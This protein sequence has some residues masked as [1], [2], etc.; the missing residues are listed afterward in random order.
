MSLRVNVEVLVDDTSEWFAF[1]GG[2]KMAKLGLEPPVLLEIDGDTKQRF[3]TT[4]EF[5]AFAQKA[6]QQWMHSRNH[7]RRN[8]QSLLVE[9]AIRHQDRYFS[10]LEVASEQVV[11]A[12]SGADARN[13]IE[14]A[15]RPFS[16]GTAILVEYAP[17]SVRD[18][19]VNNAV[20]GL[21][22]MARTIRQNSVETEAGERAVNATFNGFREQIEGI[23]E[24]LETVNKRSN[25]LTDKAVEIEEDFDQRITGWQQS[26]EASVA[27]SESRINWAN[28]H[29]VH[30]RNSYWIFGAWMICGIA[31]AIGFYKFAIPQLADVVRDT[32]SISLALLELLSRNP[33][34]ASNAVSVAAAQQNPWIRLIVVLVSIGVPGALVFWLLRQL[35]RAFLSER[36]LGLDAAERLT[37][38]DT[39]I[40]MS[41]AEQLSRDTQLV[42]AQAL[43]RPSSPISSDDAAPNAM[44]ESFL[45]KHEARE[46]S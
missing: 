2:W 26:V 41:G 25:A 7:A 21:A 18:I 23:R 39:W 8:S 35:L 33:V 31:S 11:R 20:A 40:H 10:E 44:L 29:R 5:A 1:I 3:V 15:L 30:E 34:E 16:D 6:L 19:S 9:E 24:Q 42:V 14:Q 36:H 13:L 37:M 22:A 43:F 28:K 17:N 46:N 27:T 4:D 38:L 45:R 12:P 32:S